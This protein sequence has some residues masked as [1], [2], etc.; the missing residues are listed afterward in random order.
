MAV[1]ELGE[2]VDLGQSPLSQHL[3]RL[4]AMGL[5]KA[6]R[7]GQQV[8]YSLASADVRRILETLHTIYCA[9]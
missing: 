8:R 2:K 6:R 4:R 9:P 5:V 7:Q 1:A 3:A